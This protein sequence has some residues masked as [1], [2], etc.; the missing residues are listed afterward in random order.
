MLAVD[1]CV[2]RYTTRTV[3]AIAGIYYPLYTI[4][5]DW[6]TAAVNTLSWLPF[7]PTI[8][9]SPCTARLNCSHLVQ[10]VGAVS[11][12][13]YIHVPWIADACI[14]ISIL[15]GP[16]VSSLEFPA[17]CDVICLAGWAADLFV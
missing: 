2:C 17:F 3:I 14:C 11:C 15:G 16:T 12:P 7:Q 9:Y 5:L 8:M 6:S 4:G 13:S 1:L 10:E